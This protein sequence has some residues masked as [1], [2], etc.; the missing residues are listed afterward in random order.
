M[1][2]RLEGETLHAA[3]ARRISRIDICGAIVEK[4]NNSIHGYSSN[5]VSVAWD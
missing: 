4:N 5:P 3:M 1:L 2:A